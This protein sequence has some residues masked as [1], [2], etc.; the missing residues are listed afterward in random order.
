MIRLRR[1]FVLSFWAIPLFLALM[2]CVPVR[3]RVRDID[4]RYKFRSVE[5][6]EDRDRVDRIIKRA[7]KGAVR[8]EVK[9]SP[10]DF[11]YIFRVD[12]LDV[13]DEMHGPLLY[14][15]P[16]AKAS[17]L[18]QVF[19][20]RDPK[21]EITYASID[22]RALLEVVVSFQITPGARLFYKPQGESERDISAI[23]DAEG[24]VSLRTK[25]RPRQ[26]YIYARTVSENVE[27][28]IRINVYSQEVEDINK[29]DYPA[30]AS[31]SV[32]E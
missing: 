13:L 30:T 15:D 24:R 32:S 3:E 16:T 21:F 19:N 10:E 27:R 11:D 5:R 8:K 28:F 12:T 20:A 23:V 26:T 2:S 25:I 31:E 22:I 29:E 9:D 18:K 1:P 7:A 6:Q 17:R 14:E 4:C